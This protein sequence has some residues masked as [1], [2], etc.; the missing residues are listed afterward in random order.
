MSTKE[1]CLTATIRQ[2]DNSK[3]SA[4]ILRNLEGA[5]NI[6]LYDG[7]NMASIFHI[8]PISYLTVM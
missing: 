3:K 8:V 2:T 6:L 1:R 5:F 4:Y 7:E